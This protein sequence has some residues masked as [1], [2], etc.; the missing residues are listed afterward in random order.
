M[1]II[2]HMGNFFIVN[3]IFMVILLIEASVLFK[4][5]SA[6]KKAGFVFLSLIFMNTFS[7][8]LHMRS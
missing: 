4:K 5:E 1:E 8:F 3:L 7:G 6:K 2:R